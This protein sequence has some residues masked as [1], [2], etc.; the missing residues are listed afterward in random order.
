MA[1]GAAVGAAIER[2]Y[3]VFAPYPAPVRLEASPLRDANAVLR[4]LRSAPL[5][6]L[7]GGQLLPYA[8]WAITTVGNANDY[9][10]FLPRIIELAL[11]GPRWLGADPA[12]IAGKMDLPRRNDRWTAEERAAVRTAFLAAWKRWLVGLAMMGGV[13]DALDVWRHSPSPHAV[14]HLA[15]VVSMHRSFLEDGRGI[16]GGFWDGTALETRKEVTAWV[17]SA[18]VRRWLA[19]AGVPADSEVQWW[20]ENARGALPS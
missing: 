6:E 20:I 1:H 8:A 19:C 5:R 7:Q 10:H 11:A 18:G 9:R 13:A 2:L 14:E 4:A 16:K 3:Q 17:R 15:R 12:V